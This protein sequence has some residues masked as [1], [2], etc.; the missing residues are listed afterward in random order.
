MTK[1]NTSQTRIGTNKQVLLEI[2]FYSVKCTLSYL[3]YVQAVNVP[4]QWQYIKY[5]Y[6]RL[7]NGNLGAWSP[8]LI[9]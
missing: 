5:I 1:N 6:L 2:C 4:I 7:M 9:F 8:L 3:L